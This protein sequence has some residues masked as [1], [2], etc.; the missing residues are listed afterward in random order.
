MSMT[1]K[2]YKQLAGII[3]SHI[4]EKGMVKAEDLV[5]EL[6]YWRA[7][8]NPRFNKEKFRDTCLVKSM[9]Q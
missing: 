4:N 7:F 3:N 6:S 1:R 9:P 5:K 2:D 8:D